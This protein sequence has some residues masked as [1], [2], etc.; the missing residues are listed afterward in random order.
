MPRRLSITGLWVGYGKRRP[1]AAVIRDANFSIYRGESMALMGPSGCGKTTLAKALAGLLP[2]EAWSRGGID[3]NGARVTYCVQ[4][5][6]NALNP[7]LRVGSQLSE[8]IALRKKTPGPR[9]EL[10]SLTLEALAEVGLNR[11]A[12]VVDAYPHQLS[13]GM[14]QRVLLAMALACSP[15]LLIADEVTSGLDTAGV[16]LITRILR[17]NI[18]D[19]GASLLLIT[20]EAIVARE[21]CERSL[22]LR[23]GSVTEDPPLHG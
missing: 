23:N 4:D 20:H 18:L 21:I 22:T 15:D 7:A 2:P 3:I 13:G 9:H 8:V 17:R 11:P 16:R 12:D 5:N 14:R 6:A 1:E 10:A 19:K